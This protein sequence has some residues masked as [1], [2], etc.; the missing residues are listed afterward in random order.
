MSTTYDP[1]YTSES[2]IEGLTQVVIADNNTTPS[3]AEVLVWIEQIESEIVERI[4]GSH[5][6]TDQYVDVP[7]TA[8]LSNPAQ[9][10][11]NTKTGTLSFNMP[12]GS[13]IPLTNVKSPVIAV[14]SLATNDQDPSQ[15]ASWTTRTEGPGSGSSWMLLKGGD[16]DAAYAI[17]FYDNIPYA[18]PNRIKMTYTYGYNIDS[19]IISRYCTYAVGQMVLEARMNTNDVDGMAT[20]DGGEMGTYVARHYETLIKRYQDQMDRIEEKHFGRGKKIP[21]VVI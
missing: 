14:T 21:F 1:V 6:A 5:T 4:L 10:A 11:F 19:D 13:I 7:T 17:W 9:W 15:T 16:K 12:S 18:G 8:V 20:Y 3:S 2:K